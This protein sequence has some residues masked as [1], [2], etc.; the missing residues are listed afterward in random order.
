MTHA[1]R[2]AYAADS[3]VRAMGTA[4]AVQLEG[5]RVDVTVVEGM[6]D[7]SD[8][9]TVE[10]VLR[11]GDPQTVLDLLSTAAGI[12]VRRVDERTVRL[13]SEPGR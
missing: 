7:I 1:Y 12:R 11:I 13:E 3:A 9:G 2:T 6:V 10:G 5:R 8:G 4:F